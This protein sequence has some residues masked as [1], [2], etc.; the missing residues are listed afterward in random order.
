MVKMAVY[1]E[2]VRYAIEMAVYLKA[3]RD[4]IG[5]ASEAQASE[6][7]AASVVARLPLQLGLARGTPHETAITRVR[8]NEDAT[9]DL[10]GSTAR[11]PSSR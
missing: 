11:W 7:D 10:Q 8:K 3:V 9:D 5:F 4:A 1:L 2:A 6:A